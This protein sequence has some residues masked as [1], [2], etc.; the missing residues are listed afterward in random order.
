MARKPQE[1]ALSSL[2]LISL[3]FRL[4][5][6]RTMQTSLNLFAAAVKDLELP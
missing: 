1:C 6:P 5:F 2:R 4:P 3:A